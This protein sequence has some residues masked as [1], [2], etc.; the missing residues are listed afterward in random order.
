MAPTMK[1]LLCL[2][3]VVAAYA[4]G[5]DRCQAQSKAKPPTSPRP[6]TAPRPAG[7]RARPSSA[8]APSYRKAAP[9]SVVENDIFDRSE[10][11]PRPAPT[12]HDYFGDMKA[13]LH[14]NK[15]V[16]SLSRSRSMPR[17]PGYGGMG[18]GMFG[19]RGAPA[20]HAAAAGPYSS[21]LVHPFR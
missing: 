5:A 8:P 14:T 13:G 19:A 15:S 16:P 17:M 2:A 6:F 12:R 20:H 1:R 10:M 21:S 18:G 4:A 3:A 9:Y 11:T 7:S